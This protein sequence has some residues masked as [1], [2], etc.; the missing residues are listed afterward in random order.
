M[1]FLSD[2]PAATAGCL[3]QRFRFSTCRA[4]AEACATRA[5]TIN[6]AEITLNQPQCTDCGACLFVCPV[7]AITGIRPPRRGYRSGVLCAP[8]TYP[9]PDVEELKSW[10]AEYHI[11]AVELN[12]TAAPGWALAIARLNLYLQAVNEPVWQAL[13]PAAPE[14]NAGLR[15]LLHLPQHNDALQASVTPGKRLHRRYFSR[16][17][18]YALAISPQ[19]CQLCGACGRACPEGALIFNEGGWMIDDAKCTGCKACVASCLHNAITVTAEVAPARQQ[20]IP[21]HQR[22][23]ARCRRPFLAWDAHAMHCHICCRH[24]H[25]MRS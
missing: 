2:S 11:R 18:E 4:C 10:H 22:H 3:R 12:V 17:R 6:K 21:L 7:N 15:R 5:I 14:Q 20:Y 13:P 19:N 16:Y 24:L 1:V 25:G 8:L 23:C 9:A